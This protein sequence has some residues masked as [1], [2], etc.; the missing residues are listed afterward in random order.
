MRLS[1]HA[2]GLATALF[3]TSSLAAPKQ[4]GMNVHQSQG[5]G[6]D[7]TR[8][9]GAKWVRIDLN[10]LDV[11]KTQG[12]YDW[13]V[14]DAV[15]DGA[16]Q[17]GLEV[18]A[19]IAY[20]PAWA[21][22]A[23]VKGDGP[24]NDVPK[25]GLYASFVTAAVGRYK[26]KVTHYELWN[27]PNLGDFFE[28]TPQD[29]I[30]RILVPGADAVHAACPGCKVV[31]PGLASLASSK[32]DEWLDAC[33]KAAAAKIDIVSGHV[34]AGFP[35]DGGTVGVT[36]DS[37]Y[38]R[39]ESHRVVKVGGV[40][41]FE[42]P[43]SFKEVMDANQVQKPF[44][45]TETGLEA[46]LGDAAKEQKQ[47]LYY[48]R[49]L[50]S[51]LVRPWWETTI[52]YEAFDEPPAPYTWGVVVHDEAQPKKY[53]AKPVLAFL[54]GVTSKQPAF[55]GSGADCDDLLDN[56]NDGKVDYPA[57]PDCKSAGGSTEGVYVPPPGSDG[58]PPIGGVDA[59]APEDDAGAPPEDAG[60][61]RDG[62]GCEVAPAKPMPWIAVAVAMIGITLLRR[63]RKR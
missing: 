12:Q 13:T 6:L 5:V 8:D 35:Q 50:E 37:F 63:R 34:Y 61:G 42:G 41:V 26:T 3:A 20:G 22:Q 31:A 30:S 40:T 45:L 21:S 59:G 56:D 47:V 18:L 53:R 24:H 36:S 15:V 32:Y 39:L 51:M 11:E 16:R 29:Y 14:I 33:L 27:E 7:A 52:F 48:R 62:G 58:G 19:V 38:N 28:G 44:W 54:Q 10:W 1:P 60:A 2:V 9:A 43:L 55:G 57:D 46:K 49:V 17:R 4:L 25:A 23:D